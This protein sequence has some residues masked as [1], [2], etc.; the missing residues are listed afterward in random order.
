MAAG[1]FHI[2]YKKDRIFG[3]DLM[4]A[5]AIITVLLGHSNLI[6]K[7]TAPAFANLPLPNGVELFFVLSGF[8]IGQIIFTQLTKGHFSSFGDLLRFWRFRWFRTLPN[9]YLVLVLNLGLAYFGLTKYALSSFSWKFWLFLQNFAWPFYG[10][11]P[12]SWSLAI[13]EWFYLLFPIT[14]ILTLRILR[15]LSAQ[16]VSL[17]VIAVFI[18]VPIWLKYNFAAHTTFASA[19]D[20][21]KNMRRVVIYRLDSIML[22]VLFAWFSFYYQSFFKRSRWILLIAGIL[23]NVLNRMYN[24]HFETV[25]SQTFFLV[26]QG[27]SMAM[28][29]PFFAHWRKA[30]GFLARF[31]T[32]ISVVSYAMYV[33]HF[34]LVLYPMAHFITFGDGAAAWGYYAVFFG[35]TLLLSHVLYMYFEKPMTDLRKRKSI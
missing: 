20:W 10:F 4:R 22:G 32:Y 3:L 15:K 12:E 2:T 11:Y 18:L 34:S 25:F 29:L 14:L 9:Y 13:E 16:W 35:A 19:D 1:F 30:S 31:I 33:V 27:I 23:L 24:L 21:S 17:F 28:L 6:I 5:I 8:L 26:I 7:D